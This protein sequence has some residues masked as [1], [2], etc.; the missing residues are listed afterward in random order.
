MISTNNIPIKDL[1]NYTIIY[2]YFK[3]NYQNFKD[4]YKNI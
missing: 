2:F 4:Y 1:I 3:Y